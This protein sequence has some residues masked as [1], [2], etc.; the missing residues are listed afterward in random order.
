MPDHVRNVSIIPDYF[1][2]VI[3]TFWDLKQSSSYGKD[4]EPRTWNLEQSF[5]EKL[6]DQ[7]MWN[8]EQRKNHSMKNVI[9]VI[10]Y[11]KEDLK[12][13]WPGLRCASATSTSSS[14]TS[15]SSTTMTTTS[16]TCTAKHTGLVGTFR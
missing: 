13:S 12:S 16:S 10:A 8:L 3:L 2:T 11:S 15:T 1:R 4:I 9:T 7:A 6:L 14:G 5:Y